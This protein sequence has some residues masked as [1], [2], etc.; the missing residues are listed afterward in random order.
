MNIQVFSYEE[1]INILEDKHDIN[2]ITMWRWFD[3]LSEFSTDND[4]NYILEFSEDCI[5]VRSDDFFMIDHKTD[6]ATVLHN[7]NDLTNDVRKL[8]KLGLEG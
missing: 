5:E 1:I 4:G 3:D 7:I 6:S 8:I 2:H